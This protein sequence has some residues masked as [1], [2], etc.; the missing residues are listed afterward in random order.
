M[1]DSES[2]A[3]ILK[4]VESR[5]HT[6]DRRRKANGQFLIVISVSIALGFVAMFTMGN[7][8]GPSDAMVQ[9]KEQQ[10]R[11]EKFH[12]QVFGMAVTACQNIVI[13]EARFPTKVDFDRTV[14]G[15]YVDGAVAGRVELM[16]GFGNMIPHK[17]VCT[18]DAAGNITEHSVTEG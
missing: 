12:R 10:E 15:S 17:Y 13:R 16:N 2:E 14:A 8:L 7:G 1:A 6:I 4:R 5:K 3:D 9:A 18:F 11:V